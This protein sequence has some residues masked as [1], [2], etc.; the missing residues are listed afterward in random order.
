MANLKN[1]N[2]F[3]PDSEPVKVVG[4]GDLSDKFGS[5]DEMGLTKEGK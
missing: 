3:H 2:V 5:K 1:M 4:K